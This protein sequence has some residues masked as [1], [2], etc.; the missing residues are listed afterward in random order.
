L[1][2]SRAPVIT[3]LNVGDGEGRARGETFD[4]LPTAF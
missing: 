3:T 2:S 1:M 4:D